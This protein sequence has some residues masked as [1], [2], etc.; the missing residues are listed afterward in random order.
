MHPSN[1][2]YYIEEKFL[3]INFIKYSNNAG[4]QM[5]DKK[6]IDDK[7]LKTIRD[8]CLAFSHWTF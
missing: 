6:C 3:G 7:D 1:S 5:P 2:L 4:Y 8:I